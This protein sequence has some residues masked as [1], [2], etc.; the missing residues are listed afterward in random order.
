MLPGTG[1]RVQRTNGWD[2]Q[3]ESLSFRSLKRQ[4][5]HRKWNHHQGRRRI[6]RKSVV[7]ESRPRHRYHKLRK[8]SRKR[9]SLA[10]Q[11]RF[12]RFRNPPQ[13]LLK[14]AQPILFL[15]EGQTKNFVRPVTLIFPSITIK[16]HYLIPL[17]LLNLF[18]HCTPNNVL[19]LQTNRIST[20][21]R[22]KT[23][24][25]YRT[26]HLLSR[27]RRK[28]RKTPQNRWRLRRLSHEIVQTQRQKKICQ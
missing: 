9:S 2:S 7:F 17:S 22:T 11:I 18:L 25:L 6:A 8:P 14:V 28:R 15:N 12:S 27:G 1:N 3:K 24:F 5:N 21:T 26:H 4:L 10:L 20:P 19:P 16:L 13:S 23:L